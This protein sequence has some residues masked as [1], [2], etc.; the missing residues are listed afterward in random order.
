MTTQ[1]LKQ[2]IEKVLGNSI[3][4]LLPSY[5]WKRLF[6][7]VADRIDEVEQK[8]DNLPDGVPIVSS[9]SALNRL[10]VPIGSIASIANKKT[11]K[12]SECYV[13]TA[14]DGNLTDEELF[15]KMTP[16]TGIEM[17]FP[18]PNIS[19]ADTSIRLIA[20]GG[21]SLG[22]LKISEGVC[23]AIF[24]LVGATQE[25][26]KYWILSNQTSVDG[27]NEY[28][29]QQRW[30]FY[31]DPEKVGAE[32]MALFDQIFTIVDCSSDVYVKS[33]AWEKLA[34]QGEIGSE[35]TPSTKYKLYF[36][37]NNE[38]LA[39]TYK[40][41]NR[42]AVA[43]LLA[44]SSIQPSQIELVTQNADGSDAYEGLYRVEQIR[45][46]IS[47]NQG[48]L[49]LYG[50]A[51]LQIYSDGVKGGEL[52]IVFQKDG[53]V[54]WSE[55]VAK[56]RPVVYI[57]LPDSTKQVTSSQKADNL[58]MFDILNAV[59]KNNSNELPDLILSVQNSSYY[60]TRISVAPNL[61]YRASGTNAD[62]QQVEGILF[63]GTFTDSKIIS[64]TLYSD[65]T[66]KANLLGLSAEVISDTALSTTSE[67]PLQ[68]KVV[69]AELANKQDILVSGTNIKTING[70][71]ILGEGNIVVNVDTSNLAT[72]EELATLQ[73]EVI[74]N[75]EVIAA[76]LNDL[77]KRL[78]L[79]EN[80]E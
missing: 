80:V 5:W 78:K 58:K 50:S 13:L 33:L 68:N 10:D 46:S 64:A 6:H 38:E 31:D 47:N 27:L 55:V 28:L 22:F 30:C 49:I 19:T 59:L 20:E 37:H 4:C 53:S 8:M 73:N 25:V 51:L 34:K 43:A 16:V 60:S 21:K 56:P 65:G 75:E 35:S 66:A 67:N 29:S 41:R 12:F 72:K 17:N 26:Q 24:A 7:Q 71:S 11:M 23:M 77:N 61:Y 15:A 69:T 63:I 45:T 57:P 36:V 70:E 76:T 44:D 74:A 54:R 39:D 62:G 9:E 18:L 2:Q 14:E 52:K 3:R 32:N 1:E 79:L 42:E 40:E 48:V